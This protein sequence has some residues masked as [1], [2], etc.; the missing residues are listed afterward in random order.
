M[1]WWKTEGRKTHASILSCRGLSSRNSLMV[2]E[3]HSPGI[4]LCAAVALLDLHRMLTLSS[5]ITPPS[6]ATFSNH[7]G[8]VAAARGQRDN[9]V[10]L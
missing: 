6:H 1:T 8:G 5:S 2:A 3:A 10:T 9:H 7:V 4:Q